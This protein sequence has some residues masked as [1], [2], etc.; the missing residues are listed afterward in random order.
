VFVCVCSYC[1]KE[2]LIGHYAAYET[3]ES[4]HFQ[5]SV[6][7]PCIVICDSFQSQIDSQQISN[8]IPVK[9]RAFKSNLL[10]VRSNRPKWFHHDLKLPVTS[11]RSSVAETASSRDNVTASVLGNNCPFLS[12]S[13]SHPPAF[14]WAHRG[15]WM[16][17]MRILQCKYRCRDRESWLID[18][19]YGT[20]Y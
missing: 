11:C 14:C 20:S 10:V 6:F 12:W 7:L 2:L 18:A 19:F 4:R 17:W 8:Q 9:L 15:R 5:Y 16:R 3:A 1:I 13:S